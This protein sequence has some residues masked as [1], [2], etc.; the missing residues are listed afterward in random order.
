MGVMLHKAVVEGLCEGAE[1]SCAE[2]ARVG[3]FGAERAEVL[4]RNGS[5]ERNR[6]VDGQIRH[7][8]RHER[9]KH[10]GHRLEDDDPALH[11]EV[12]TGIQ[13]PKL[14]RMDLSRYLYP[15]N[16]W[17]RSFGIAYGAYQ[18][19][20][21]DSQYIESLIMRS[22]QISGPPETM[23]K[24]LSEF[25]IRKI[26]HTIRHDLD[27]PQDIVFERAFDVMRNLMPTVMN[28]ESGNKRVWHFL[29]NYIIASKDDLAISPQKVEVTAVNKS[30][31]PPQNIKPQPNKQKEPVKPGIS[32]PSDPFTKSRRSVRNRNRH[33]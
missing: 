24:S 12:I 2:H 10:E 4:K 28:M 22:G 32:H 5:A 25:P 29:K 6:K 33:S 20:Y 7:L 3:G 27:S 8:G 19:I 9:D 18:K 30:E 17:M 15:T 23:R 31:V 14:Q 1:V 13:I 16:E 11:P 21:G 26:M